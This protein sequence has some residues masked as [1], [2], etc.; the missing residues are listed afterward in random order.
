MASE[1][2]CGRRP[3]QAARTFGQLCGSQAKELLEVQ[4]VRRMAPMYAATWSCTVVKYP[5]SIPNLERGVDLRL[6]WALG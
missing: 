2:E 3:E 4:A 6:T 5:T 1:Y